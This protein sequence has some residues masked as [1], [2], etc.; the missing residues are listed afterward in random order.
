L[1]QRVEEAVVA[2]DRWL[3]NNGWAGYDPYDVKSYILGRIVTGKMK[4][5]QVQQL[6]Q[7]DAAD[8]AGLRRELGIR[9]AVNA[10][11]MALL[12]GAYLVLQ[13]LL[14]GR[15]FSR[16]IRET[17]QW[18]LDNPT[19]GMS[20][21]AWGYPFDWESVVMIP[22]GCPTGVI[23]YHAGDAFWL[24]WQASG[25]AAW[26]ERCRS[27]ATFM[28]RDLNQ[29]HLDPDTLCFSYT[30]L[31]F[32]HVH[33]ASLCV[34]EFL[35]R[36]GQ[37]VEEPEW[38]ELGRKAVRFALRDLS[39]QGYLTYWARGFEPTTQNVDQID[40]YHTAAE[41]RSLLRLSRL[42]PDWEELVQATRRYL[43]FYL[44]RFFEDGTIPKIHPQRT[45]PV[46]IHAAAEA[47]Y[48]LGEAAADSEPAA[49]VLRRF[50]P[51]FLE[52]CANP[53][54][55]FLYQL[56]VVEGRTH[57]NRFPFLRWGQAWTM[58]GLA[59]ALA[60]LSGRRLAQAA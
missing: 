25:E 33:N 37:Q 19:P 41:L 48:V 12:L 21:L 56:T 15:D 22:A 38:V 59:S 29:D 31:D 8:P 2:L 53:D 36:V 16:Q 4:P 58:R 11:A 54:G 1:A 6:L 55:S 28:A 60:A 35:V 52:Q 17:G 39:A 45:Y 9:P 7:R 47:A 43:D 10:K 18:L 42:L 49:A 24:H 34:A 32:Y 3:E 13:E 50:L 46:D 51:W 40:H 57:K 27:V 14:P 30:P 44:E 23:S 20:G 26:L 5:Q